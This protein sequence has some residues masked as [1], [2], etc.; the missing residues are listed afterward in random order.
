VRPRVLPVLLL[1]L[2]LL[3]SCTGPGVQGGDPVTPTQSATTAAPVRL[4]VVAEADP[5]AAAEHASR[6]LFR[7]ADV[8][9]LARD[10]DRPGTLLGASAAVSLGVPL[11][12]QPAGGDDAG[13][14]REL[15]RLGAGT[16]LAVGAA[17]APATAPGDTRRTVIAV[18]ATPASLAGAGV[19]LGRPLA[20][21]PDGAATAI[22]GLQPDTPRALHPP[23]GAAPSA[24]PS[25]SLSASPSASASTSASTSPSARA[26]AGKPR[27]VPAVHRGRPLADTVVLGTG[28][29]EVLAG[30]ATARAA[31]A[32][33]V[34]TDGPDPRASSAVVAALAQARPTSVMALGAPFAGDHDLDWQ[35]ATATTGR[36]LPGGGQLVFPGRTLV[37]LYGTPGTAALGVLGEQGLDASIARA[38]QHAARYDKLIDGPVVPTFEIIATVAS[39][40][41]G[42][43]G[44]YSTEIDPATLRPWVVA[45]QR[46]GLYVVLDLQP[47]RA[48]FLTQAKQYQSLLAL[49]NVG[50]ALDPEWRLGPGELPLQ[51]IGSV[52]IDEINR[53]AGWL[54]ALTRSKL[55]PQKLLVLHQFRVSM[56]QG[57]DRLD[58]SHPEL[59]V[60]LHADGQGTQGNKQ[61]TWRTLHQDLPH[62]TLFWGWK[63]FYDEDHPM[64]TPEQT[65]AQVSP[66]PDLISYQ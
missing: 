5:A 61:A 58:T 51:Q 24:T 3:C 13:V 42:P 55:L 44:N 45:A 34:L 65:V 1:A 2:T 50:L 7:S 11:L 22:A 9:V 63:N 15:D 27:R 52:G 33:V 19:R 12:L 64:L 36:Q 35:L 23:A 16:V 57:R 8:A 47:G 38:R 41:A 28:G 40:V 60:V 17:A 18:A 21:P 49:P 59:A 14:A 31:G 48:D 56:I 66:R 29:P 10:G 26:S 62:G 43:D 30:L 54:A 46:A 53:V 39:A 4:T 20:V 37:A 25:A 32:R 6:V